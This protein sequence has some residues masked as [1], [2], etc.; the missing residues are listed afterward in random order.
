MTPR[1]LTLISDHGPH[2]VVHDVKT[3]LSTAVRESSESREQV[4]DR[5]N[6]LA[7]RHGI[8]L[9]GNAGLSK[10]MFDKWLN[11]EDDSR[12]PGIKGLVLLCLALDT[13][14]PLDAIARTIGA[15]VI[16]GDDITLLEL[17]R[18][19]Q[20]HKRLRKKM[21]KLEEELG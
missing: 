9:S 15:K 18:A 5:V 4:L 1:Q 20:E 17:A 16:S 13:A 21:R 19:Q 2:T 7:K 6:T 3:A 14:E 12:V 11:A 8:K 10:D